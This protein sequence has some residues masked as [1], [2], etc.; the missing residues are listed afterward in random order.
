MFPLSISKLPVVICFLCLL[1]ACGDR[2]DSISN[3]TR[4]A[5]DH[6]EL[7]PSFQALLDSIHVEGS[8]LI[9]DPEKHVYYSN[10]FQWARQ[11]QLPA[12]TFKI[13]NSIIAL[14]TRIVENE[15]VNIPWDGTRRSV[16]NWNQDLS[17]KDAFAYSCVPCYQGFVREVGPDRMRQF[18]SKLK[19]PGI[20][21]QDEEIDMFWLQGESHINQFEQIEFLRRFRENELPISAKTSEILRNIML[22]DTT[23]SYILSGKTGWSI[24]GEKNNGWFVGFAEADEKVLYFATNIEPKEGTPIEAFIKGRRSLTEAALMQH[25]WSQNSK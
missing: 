15:E 24:S 12:S 25:G 7:T 10:N 11:G 14:E 5:K 20:S 4:K 22:I 6:V 19:Y 13:P 9:Y 18:I 2:G 23:D 17:F 21:F 3:H 1:M 8:I 16:E